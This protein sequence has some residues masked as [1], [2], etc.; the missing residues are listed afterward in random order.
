MDDIKNV[1]VGHR[2]RMIN[3]FVSNPDAMADH[4]LLEVLLFACIPRKDTNALAHR[5]LR[6]F[7]SLEKVF[8]ADVKDLMK[9]DGIGKK[10]ATYIK[11]NGLIVN[12]IKNA[13]KQENI[14]MSSFY[15]IKDLVVED[16]MGLKEEQFIVY[17]LDKSFKRITTLTY[18]NDKPDSVFI[19]PSELVSAFAIHKPSH[20]I[21]AH[22]HPSGNV[23][24]SKADDLNTGRVFV[25]CSLHNITLLDHVIVFEHKAY[26]YYQEGRL[27]KIKKT[28]DFD[29]IFSN[30]VKGYLMEE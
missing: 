7:G 2:E 8:N 13:K 19:E 15:K 1:H 21:L 5:V 23:S 10:A 16:F 25:I 22:N 28:S 4:E 27:D 30:N 3:K 11:V 29:A 26:S 17:L 20:L 12:R 6:T 14:N 9:V 18:K 24:P